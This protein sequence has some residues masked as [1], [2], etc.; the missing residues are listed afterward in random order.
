MNIQDG[1][2][3]VKKEL[4]SDEQ[5]LASA[6]K[7]EKLYKK[8]KIKIFTVV[9]LLVAFFGGK[10]IMETIENSRLNSANEAYLAL[11]KDANNA[12]ALEE[13]K[14]K[15]PKLFELYT[16][17][18]AVQNRDTKELQT[19]SNSKNEFISD[20]SNYHLSVINSK[21]VDSKLYREFALVNNAVIY[22]RDGNMN[23]ARNQLS[24][25]D[26]KSPV[27]NISKIINH[28]TIKGK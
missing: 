13:L 2:N 28:Y 4:T 9:G 17:K 24:L 10:A 20:M 22:I 23:E 7:L 16:Y 15:N 26:E 14:S 21:V 3:E 27:Y 6:F 1:I 12:K 25:I 11:Q 19:L 18:K 5:M 8:H